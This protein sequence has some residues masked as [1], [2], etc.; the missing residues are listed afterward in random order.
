M[1]SLLENFCPLSEQFPM[2]H[3]AKEA[4]E[5]LKSIHDKSIFWQLGSRRIGYLEI[6]PILST[7]GLG[8]NSRT[9]KFMVVFNDYCELKHSFESLGHEIGHTFHFDLTKNPP[10]E[11]ID[12]NS[13]EFMYDFVDG[14]PKGFLIEDFCDAF[15][16]RWMAINDREKVNKD[17]ADK[18]DLL[19]PALILMLSNASNRCINP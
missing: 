6:L 13:H 2:F 14:H 4:D 3:F 10:V 15:S 1:K 9:G 8:I 18:E 12:Q 19:L 17:C 16:L 5:W 7:A 11:I